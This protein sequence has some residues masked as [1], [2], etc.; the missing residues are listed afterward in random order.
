MTLNNRRLQEQTQR[1]EAISIPAEFNQHIRLL[2][3]PFFVLGW[4]CWTK[5]WNSFLRVKTND[6][7]RRLSFSPR[8]CR[9][10]LNSGNIRRNG[11][12]RLWK[13]KRGCVIN[14]PTKIKPKDLRL[15]GVKGNVRGRRKSGEGAG[16]R[17]GHSKL[18]NISR[19]RT[20]CQD[21]EWRLRKSKSERNFIYKLLYL[22]PSFYR[23]RKLLPF[24]LS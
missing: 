19:H 24:D 10:W 17:H 16:K 8:I 9:T 11:C 6:L 3:Q 7:E 12:W 21:T 20:I 1:R 23:R 13:A 2:F 4:G 14:H 22:K 15:E 5:A 18:K